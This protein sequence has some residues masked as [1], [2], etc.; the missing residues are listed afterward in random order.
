L[1]VDNLSAVASRLYR[2]FKVS[3][4]DFS[5]IQVTVTISLSKITSITV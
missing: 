1:R 4:G 3:Y 5:F 2:H